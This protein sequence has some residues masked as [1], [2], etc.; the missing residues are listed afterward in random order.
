[1]APLVLVAVL[2]AGLVVF[3][4]GRIGHAATLR[5]SAQ[6]AADASALAGAA[7]GR[8]AAASIAAENHADLV[9][10]R[11]V[12]DDVVVTVRRRGATATARA[13]WVPAAIP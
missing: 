10:F 1:V 12:G 6:A 11:Q 2:F 8:D 5:A 13:R 3:G 4:V 7:D 9:S